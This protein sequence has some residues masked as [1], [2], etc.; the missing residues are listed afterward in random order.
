MTTV[1]KI[2][3]L[4]TITLLQETKTIEDVK[5]LSKFTQPRIAAFVSEGRRQYFVVAEQSV[6]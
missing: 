5:K 1:I 4:S 3:C 2:C 6:V